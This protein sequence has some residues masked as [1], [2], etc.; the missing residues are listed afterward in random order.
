MFDS[1]TVFACYACW[2][3]FKVNGNRVCVEWKL[4]WFTGFFRTPVSFSVSPLPA[5]KGMNL[6]SFP[7][8]NMQLNKEKLTY[9]K[10]FMWELNIKT[11][12]MKVDRKHKLLWPLIHTSSGAEHLEACPSGT[13]ERRAGLCAQTWNQETRET[14]THKIITT[15]TTTRTDSS[16]VSSY[17]TANEYLS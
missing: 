4:K 8:H 5:Y 2:D 11:D 3:N 13:P 1:F 6:L 14:H 9:A 16:D 10:C 17:Y 12:E 7:T 15:L